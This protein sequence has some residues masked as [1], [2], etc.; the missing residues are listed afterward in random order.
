MSQ[1][2]Q[3]SKI[4]NEHFAWFIGEG[5]SVSKY[6]FY[7]T[8]EKVARAPMPLGPAYLD[9]RVDHDFRHYVLRHPIGEGDLSFWPPISFAEF[10][11]AIERTSPELRNQGL[12]WFSQSLE[13][14]VF[15]IKEMAII[16]KWRYQ[17][18]SVIP[19]PD[20]LI[21]I[22]TRNRNELQSLTL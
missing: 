11:Q 4:L 17:F 7:N 16:Y 19:C 13:E 14:V 22:L 20:S 1:S 3:A 2:T 10:H 21:M 15:A 9:I 5:F 18:Q 6:P 8:L 12:F